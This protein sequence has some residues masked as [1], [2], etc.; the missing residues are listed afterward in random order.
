MYK[1]KL[2]NFQL[3]VMKRG[4]DYVDLSKTPKS[5]WSA[6]RN[7]VFF[8]AV[9]QPPKLQTSVT[10]KAVVHAENK[11]IELEYSKVHFSSKVLWL[12]QLGD[13]LLKMIFKKKK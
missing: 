4:T 12:I 10:E 6:Y 13:F 1:Q 2:N 8:T 9:S 7:F 11:W 3:P 5:L